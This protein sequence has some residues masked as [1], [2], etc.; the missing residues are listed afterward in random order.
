MRHHWGFLLV[1]CGLLALASGLDAGGRGKAKEGDKDLD[2]VKEYL[3]QKYPNK[4]WQLGPKSISSDA[5]KKAYG[6]EVKY[7]YVHSSPPLPPGAPLPDLIKAYQAK[8]KD[9]LDNH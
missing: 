6:M 4:K 3:K 9:Y 8:Y 2:A 5:I 7:F 1:L